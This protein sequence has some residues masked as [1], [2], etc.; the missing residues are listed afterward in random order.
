MPPEP[1]EEDRAESNG[2]HSDGRDV[3][4][5]RTSCF[6]T[7]CDSPEVKEVATE[8]G[9]DDVTQTLSPVSFVESSVPD[10]VVAD[11]EIIVL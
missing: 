10:A 9:H 3:I 11:R 1:V 6:F 8:W 4:P 7:D 5:F 2:V